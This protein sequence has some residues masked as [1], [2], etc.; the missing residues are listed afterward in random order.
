MGMGTE[1]E[2]EGKGKGKGMMRRMKGVRGSG[3]PNWSS[4]LDKESFFSSSL[5]IVLSR[6]DTIH[7]AVALSFFTKMLFYSQLLRTWGTL[8]TIV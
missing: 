7:T 5:K 1:D 8:F 6:P 2:K 4:V 3:W